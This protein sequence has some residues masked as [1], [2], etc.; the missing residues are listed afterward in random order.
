MSLLHASGIGIRLGGQPILAQVDTRLES[1]EMLG[2]IGPNGAGKSTLLKILGGILSPDAGECR[3]RGHPY[4]RAGAVERARGIAYLAQQGEAHWPLPVS[5]LVA[6]GRL[7]HLGPW[8]RPGTV[9]RAAIR[10]ALEVTDLLPLSDRSFATLSGGE[11]ARALLARA[12][13]GEPAV[14]LAD[15]PV[16][17]LDP[18]HQLD[19]MALLRRHCEAGGAASVVRHDLRLASH[20]CNRLQLLHRG[21]T[22]AVGPPFEVLGEHNLETAYGI[23]LRS[24]FSDVRQAL[25]LAWERRS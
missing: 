23:G 11:K 17:A 16:A 14:L 8:Q 22:L 20:Y 25:A 7:P 13:A 3:F 24:R 2:L 4:D 18:A 1:G 19:V 6:L 12:L 10:R 9:D 5:Q 21:R 15:E